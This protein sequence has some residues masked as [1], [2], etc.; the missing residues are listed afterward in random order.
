MSKLLWVLLPLLAAA[1]AAIWLTWRGRAPSRMTL[2]V[3]VSLLLLAYLLVTAG[4]GIFWVANQHLP[5]FDWHY[6]FGYAVLLLLVVHLAFNARVVVHHLRRRRSAPGVPPSPA[7]ST[8]RPALALVGVAAAALA[9]Y[10]VGMR[11]GRTELRVAAGED[12]AAA[13]VAL[14]VVDEF[15]AF[16]AHSRTGLLRR[17]PGADWGDAPPPFK[18]VDAAALRPL[19]MQAE[20]AARFDA[21]ALG[22]LLWHVAGIRERRGAIAFRTAPSAGALFA[23]ELYVAARDVAGLAP[24]LWRHAAQH[25]ALAP[26]A[27]RLDAAALGLPPAALDGALAVVVATAVFRRSGHKYR[28]RTYRYV[29]AD[30]GHALENLRVAA[31]ALG[32]RAELLRHFD[33]AR[34]A[35]A[36]GVDEA[37]EGV[38]AVAVLRRAGASTPVAA[39]SAPAFVAAPL[40]AGTAPLGITDAVHRATSLRVA[41]ASSWPSAPTRT[42]DDALPDGPPT[43]GTSQP[44]PPPRPIAADPLRTIAARRSIR[45]YAAAPLALAD[46]SD[47]LAAM[48]APPPL[49][50]GAVR[51]DVL[52]HAVEGLA[53][54]AWR[55]RPRSRAL[56][57]RVAHDA[58]L[59]RRSRAVALAQDTV[60]DAAAVVVLSIDR[61][62]WTAE[63]AGAAR[64]YRLA[65][66][67]AGLLGERLYLAAGARGLG[68][69]A[70]GA[71]YDDEAAALVG[72]DPAHEW[73]VHFASVGVPA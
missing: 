67:E 39:P 13:D 47:L 69:C 64:G 41:T 7:A 63:P 53:S 57:L 58:A 4:L 10:A 66:L 44:L 5:V 24:G 32:A 16:S 50:S 34:I 61:R 46:L 18:P 11:H 65:F 23:T 49:L 26:L 38:L 35:A 27:G 48:A 43:D 22:V 2:N 45:R 55:Y 52:A 59:R 40:P 29:L 6:L 31:E 28:D 25:H 15:H 51:I 33:E 72:A 56:A 19:P 68:V 17:A 62:A 30:L 70:V 21:A 60:G 37:E 1:L 36:L 8:R 3:A 12:S 71:F 54:G 9:G 73:V 14:A 42:V 20:G